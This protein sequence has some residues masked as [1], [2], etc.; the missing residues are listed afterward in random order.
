MKKI[1]FGSISKDFSEDDGMVQINTPKGSFMFPRDH[2]PDIVEMDIMLKS[3]GMDM[4]M[5]PN[6]V[7]G[8]NNNGG[9]GND[10]PF[11]FNGGSQW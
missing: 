3:M 9:F 8:N 1:W 11:N 4:S 5:D 2:E 7:F 10:D 6:D